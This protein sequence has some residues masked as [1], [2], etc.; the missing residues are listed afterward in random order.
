MN[1]LSRIYAAA[2][3]GV[4]C[5]TGLFKLFRY[6]RRLNIDYEFALD[7]RNRFIQFCNDG[8]RNQMEYSWLI[9]HSPQ[10]Q[11]AMGHYGVFSTFRPPFANYMLREYPIIL[12]MIPEIR[13]LNSQNEFGLMKNTPDEYVHSVDEALIRYIGSF[14]HRQQEV[15]RN[16]WNPVIW[17]R[18]GMR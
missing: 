7:F 2:A 12:N 13:K 14:E 18:E 9:G 4:V 11:I 17:F 10:M 3:I 5:I 1:W 16:L 8:F 15:S 6:Q